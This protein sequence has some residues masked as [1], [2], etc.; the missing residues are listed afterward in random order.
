MLISNQLP[1]VK[2]AQLLNYGHNKAISNYHAL[3]L[4]FIIPHGSTDSIMFPIKKYLINYGSSCTLFMFQPMRIKFLFLFL[5]SLFHIKNDI[6]G[7]LWVQLIYTSS[8]HLSWVWFPEWAISYLAW[9]HVP[10]HYYKVLPFLNKTQIIS[11][12]LT[13]LFTYILIQKYKIDE[14][15]MGGSWIPLVI[16]HIM[17]NS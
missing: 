5:Y 11:L 15:S 13:Q 12:I 17:T 9:I 3:C 1:I 6:V 14:L 7:P 8:V 4:S 10:L 16:G 2:K